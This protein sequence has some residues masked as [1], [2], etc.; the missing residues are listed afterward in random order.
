MRKRI[1]AFIAVGALFAGVVPSTTAAP[2]QQCPDSF[3]FD[4]TQGG[5]GEHD[6]N[7]NGFVCKG[8]PQLQAVVDDRIILP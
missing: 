5:G 1:A 2:K 6:R 8:G 7:S 3:I 4:T